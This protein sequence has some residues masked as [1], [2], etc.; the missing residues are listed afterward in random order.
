VA[1]KEIEVVLLNMHGQELDR[2]SK[3]AAR[4]AWSWRFEQNAETET[5]CYALTDVRQGETRVLEHGNV[6]TETEKRGTV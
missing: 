4:R 5:G 3:R 6:S 2:G 1:N